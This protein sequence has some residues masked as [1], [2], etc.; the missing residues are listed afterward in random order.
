METCNTIHVPV[1]SRL[2]I[3]KAEDEPE[4]NMMSVEQKTDIPT[5]AHVRKM[6]DVTRT[7]IAVSFSRKTHHNLSD[8]DKRK[9]YKNWANS[10]KMQCRSE[11]NIQSNLEKDVTPMDGTAHNGV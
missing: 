10:K 4:I 9:F 3:S 6:A 11:E 1:E 5:R 8:E 2:K 7:L